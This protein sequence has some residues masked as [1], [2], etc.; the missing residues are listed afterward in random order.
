M[1]KLKES[2]AKLDKLLEK[3]IANKER[4]LALKEEAK[5]LRDAYIKEEK[6]REAELKAELSGGN[7]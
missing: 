1:S 6:I 7:K 4:R 2:Q 5:E 3:I